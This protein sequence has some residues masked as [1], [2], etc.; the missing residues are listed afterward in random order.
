MGF[1]SYAA[2]NKARDDGLSR[3]DREFVE[4]AMVGGMT[5]VELGKLAQQKGTSDA[6]KRFGQR[7]VDDHSKAGQ[8]LKGIASKV[9]YAPKK[10]PGPD[11]KH[12][13]A[14]SNKSSARFD[15]EYAEE[16]VDDHEKTVKLFRKQ[17]EKGDNA[18]LKQFAAKAL[19]TFEE[20][21]KMSRDLKN[22][23]KGKKK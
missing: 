5:E 14:L 12:I 23:T 17:A 4:K 20:H 13:K 19:P 2:D 21:L 7:M 10:E 6:V 11:Q 1:A 8:E 15:H 22:E 18:E 3:G 9:G 16:M